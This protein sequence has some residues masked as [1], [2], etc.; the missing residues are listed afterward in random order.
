MAAGLARRLLEVRRALR[1]DLEPRSSKDRRF[2]RIRVL[3]TNPPRFSV[4]EREEG[5]EVFAVS[6]ALTLDETFDLR[7]VCERC[8]APCVHGLAALDEL[9]DWLFDPDHPRREE[10]LEAAREPPW[11]RWLDALDEGLAAFEEEAS[12]RAVARLWWSVDLSTLDIAPWVDRPMRSGGFKKPQRIRLEDVE[13]EVAASDADRAAVAAARL[14]RSERRAA[15]RDGSERVAFVRAL[16][17]LEG[18]PRVS[19]GGAPGGIAW[20]VERLP[21]RFTIDRSGDGS[22]DLRLRAGDIELS[23][24]DVARG[25]DEVLLFPRADERRLGLARI[26]PP[27]AKLLRR[28]ASQAVPVPEPAHVDFMQRVSRA[29]QH[30]AVAGSDLVGEHEV[31]PR[32]DLVALLRPLPR[33][34]RGLLIE[35]RVRPLEDGPLFKPGVPP[36][37]VL[38]SSLDRQVLRT[39]RDLIGERAHVGRVL[40]ELELA[41]DPRDPASIVLT[42]LQEAIEAVD[43]LHRDPRIECQWPDKTWHPP[44]SLGPE[45]LRIHLEKKRDFLGIHGEAVVDGA[46]IDLAVL[47][48]AA[49]RDRGYVALDETRFARLTE[50]LIARLNELAPHLEPAKTGLR[51]Q[52]AALEPSLQLLAE[53]GEAKGDA[54]WEAFVAR[55]ERAKALEPK[56]P[57]HLQDVLRPYQREGFA[58]MARLSAW[59]AGAVLADDMGLGKTLQTIAVLSTRSAIGPQLVVAPTSVTF[60]WARELARFAPDL[61]VLPY[62]GERREARLARAQTG[63]VVVASYGVLG[64]DASFLREVSWATLVVDEAQALKNPKTRRARA[65]RSLR[66]DWAVALTGTP[67]ENHPIDLWSLFDIVFPGLLGSAETFRARFAMDAEGEPDLMMGR[68]A[69]RRAVRPF[70]LRR[71]KAE[72]APELP[73]RTDVLIDVTLSNRER[74]LYEDAR[75]AAL[76]EIEGRPVVEWTQLHLRVLAALTRLRQ[77]ACHPRLVDPRSRVPSSKLER[78]MQVLFDLE[79]EGRRALVFSQFTQHLALVREALDERG[80]SYLY[81]D[82]KTPPKARAEA[83]DRFQEGVA[84]LFLISLKAGGTGLNLARADTVI[85]LDPWWNPAV[86]DQATDRAHRIGQTQP[87]TVIRLVTRGTIEEKMLEVHADKRR[88]FSELLEGGDHPAGLSSEALIELIRG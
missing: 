44:V 69:L 13:R 56:V 30:V 29:A 78:L 23:F 27:L 84:P 48:E 85:L 86:E 14:Y 31:E 35:V 68:S 66:A 47:I 28:W 65:A 17:A 49:R 57:R 10:V 24:A 77:L 62:Q 60:N 15:A 33:P 51:L 19:V 54:A 25:A 70:V 41:E 63:V 40:A 16:E 61:E 73:P 5:G 64:R 53:A 59:G 7:P 82:G 46:R 76:A 80:A 75:L 39:R 81:L 87:V 36:E 79:E 22:L 37:E 50:G 6:V 12:R 2:D 21:L 4:T 11:K 18:H 43:R 38:A 34:E 58:W 71:T 55:I 9:L 45:R 52:L 20:R 32:L 83:V 26:D 1:P 3:D 67:V 8:H 74:A 42:D 72:V 88:L